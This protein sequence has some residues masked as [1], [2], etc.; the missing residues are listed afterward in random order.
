MKAYREL[1]KEELLTLKEELSREYEDIKAKGLS[2]DMSRG[3]PGTDQ[4]DLSMPM[5]DL[6]NSDSDMKCENALDRVFYGVLEGIPEA[7]RLMSEMIGTDPEHVIVFG[8][9]S[10]NVMF[11]T[12]ARCMIRGVLGNTPWC[13]LD[14]VKFLCPAPA[15]T[16]ILR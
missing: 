5:L 12:V 9:S 15:M 1:R 11:D 14:Q 2:L 6:V 16:A 4:L 3:K 8:N 7:K 10:L 13:K